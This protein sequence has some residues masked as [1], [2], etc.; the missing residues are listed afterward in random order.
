MAGASP[1]GDVGLRVGKQEFIDEAGCC[2]LPRSRIQVDQSRLQVGC[3]QSQ[4]LS[5]AP[6]GRA[7]KFPGYSGK[8]ILIQ[9]L[10]APGNEPDAVGWSRADIAHALHKGQSSGR[11]PCYILLHFLSGRRRTV[12]IKRHEVHYSLKRRIPGQSLQEGAPGFSLLRVQGRRSNACAFIR[13][14]VILSLSTGDEH[15]LIS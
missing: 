3:F 6:Q 8:V 10:R 12:P 9:D 14:L 2:R 11:G 7:G 5:E 13:Y 1:I 15:D 4:N